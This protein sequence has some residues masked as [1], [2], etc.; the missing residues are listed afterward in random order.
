MTSVLFCELVD[1]ARDFFDGSGMDADALVLESEAV[2][3]RLEPCVRAAFRA[4]AE[5][6]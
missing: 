4:W 1:D 3:P 5:F 2:L 6:L